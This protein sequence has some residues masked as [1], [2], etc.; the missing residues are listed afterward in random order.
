MYLDL[1]R[2]ILKILIV[3]LTGLV[4]DSGKYR[5][6]RQIFFFNFMDIQRGL[7]VYEEIK[8]N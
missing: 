4:A 1:Q 8:K 5:C 3:L 6:R 2:L 7:W